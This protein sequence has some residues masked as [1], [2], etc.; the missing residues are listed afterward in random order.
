MLPLVGV[1]YKVDSQP[2]GV[3][4]PV[5][6]ASDVLVDE[7]VGDLQLINPNGNLIVIFRRGQDLPF[8][9]SKGFHYYLI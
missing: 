4:A 1:R 6:R 5:L 7:R 3:V 9:S 2:P 8:D